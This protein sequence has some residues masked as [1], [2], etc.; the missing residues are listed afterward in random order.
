M[1]SQ[2][3]SDFL[4]SNELTCLFVCWKEIITKTT[5][6]SCREKVP[7]SNSRAWVR[8]SITELLIQR[9]EDIGHG[10]IADTSSNK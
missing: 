4:R 8:A 10:E 9:E 2:F 5:F 3:Q 7:R 6:L 1:K